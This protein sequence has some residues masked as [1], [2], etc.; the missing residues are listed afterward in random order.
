MSNKK[1]ITVN[2]DLFNIGTNKT[3]KNRGSIKR[4]PIIKPIIQPNTLK[5]KLLKRIKEHK[6]IENKQ[7]NQVN[8]DILE[9]DENNEY[10]DEFNNA[11]NYLNEL[12][13]KRD[14]DIEKENYEKSVQRKKD[15]LQKKTLKNY[16]S[17]YSQPMPHVELE[18]PPE[19]QEQSGYNMLLSSHNSSIIYDKNTN[20]K[21]DSD[22]PY[23]CLKKGIK[24]SYRS[25]MQQ[26][27]KNPHGYIDTNITTSNNFDSSLREE[28]L[29][30]IKNKLKHIEQKNLIKSDPKLNELHG[31]LDNLSDEEVG[32]PDILKAELS[33]TS[34]HPKTIIKKTIRRKFTLGKSDKYRKVG[35]LVKDKRTRKNILNAQRELKKTPIHE[36]K[37]YLKNHGMIKVGTIAPNDILRKT[38]E[39]SMLAGEITNI[40]K[41]V[42]VHNMLNGDGE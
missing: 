1:T 14:R 34:S 29:A 28:K 26:T 10:T 30:Q 33:N 36:I 7:H 19:L 39:A 24:P 17:Y 40:N 21:V 25:W 12:S 9:E 4:E 42:F 32:V 2:P 27:R 37:K 35:V 20:Y 41:D 15:E 3:K 6:I 5:N 8:N 22:V 38:Y 11:I 31:V 16:Q 23:G 18:L 13:K